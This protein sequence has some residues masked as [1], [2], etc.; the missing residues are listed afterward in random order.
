MSLEALYT[1]LKA[2]PEKHAA[3]GAQIYV[4]MTRLE[5]L[6][7]SLPLRHLPWMP[8]HP[9][10]ADLVLLKHHFPKMT[11]P[12]PDVATAI[13]VA[14]AVADCSAA[15]SFQH[16][17][18]DSIFTM[19]QNHWI[20]DFDHYFTARLP[21][22]TGDPDYQSYI[23]A[24]RD[25]GVDPL[26]YANALPDV[27]SLHWF[28]KDVLEKLVADRGT[29]GHDRPVTVMLL[30][31]QDHNGA[32]QREPD[33]ATTILDPGH[34]VLLAQGLGA[35]SEFQPLLEVW[36]ATY[37]DDGQFEEVLFNGH[38]SP[39]GM[40]L[41]AKM[42]DQGAI[43][44][45]ESLSYTGATASET[46]R[47]LAWL[48]QHTEIG[49]AVGLAAC[50]TNA[51]PFRPGQL[52]SH[53]DVW[54]TDAPPPSIAADEPSWED[55]RRQIL[56]PSTFAEQLALDFPNQQVNGANGLLFG[57]IGRDSRGNLSVTGF[58]DPDVFLVKL[59][60]IKSGRD[61][62][63]V[64]QAVIE[65]AA[66][67]GQDHAMLLMRPVLGRPGGALDPHPDSEV[68]SHD[69]QRVASYGQLHSGPPVSSVRIHAQAG[70]LPVASGGRSQRP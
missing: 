1:E 43:V 49:G 25:D 2:H 47:L 14:G 12:L 56:E 16:A 21:V 52:P 34:R 20:A 26:R 68:L 59:D 58:Q 65:I 15:G 3:L 27:R 55:I 70:G 35:V 62:V 41:A 46:H 28:I 61:P 8:L 66:F 40:E 33:M 7:Q 38:G 67:H 10:W 18:E 57:Q 11:S 51:E 30:S 54:D 29:P 64:V 23:A 44:G 53:T 48:G 24:R 37:T 60:Y 63:G 32:L 6:A 19:I 31:A 4:S 39:L 45:E 17:S 50:S 69:A 42:D 9:F 13:A 22:I 36:A 5:L